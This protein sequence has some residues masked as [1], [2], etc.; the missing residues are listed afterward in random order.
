MFDFLNTFIVGILMILSS[1]YNYDFFSV[2]IVILY[3]LFFPGLSNLIFVF[4][5][6]A[7]I[8]LKS[9]ELSQLWWVV[10]GIITF[11]IVIASMFTKK[12]EEP[13]EG[14]G[15]GDLLKMLGNQQ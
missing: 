1:Q 3:S 6:A 7:I 8:F 13:E 10:L 14:G 4:G 9:G 2:I 5:L 12:E 15:Y 11:I